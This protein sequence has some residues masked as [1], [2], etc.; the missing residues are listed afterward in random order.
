MTGFPEYNGVVEW[1][2]EDQCYIGSCPGTIGP[3]CHGDDEDK[4]HRQLR[5]VFS[6]W[7][8]IDR[9]DNSQ[10]QT[11]LPESVSK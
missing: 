9:V 3:C 1:S 5:Q 7:L 2:D 10:S 11:R 8:E 6:E 4:V